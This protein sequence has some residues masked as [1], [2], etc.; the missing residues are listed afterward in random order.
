MTSSGPV[1]DAWCYFE[2]LKALAGGGDVAQVVKVFEEMNERGVTP[3]V[4]CY[5]MVIT[6]L[7]KAGRFRE[8]RGLLQDMREGVVRGVDVSKP[9]A[10]M[11]KLGNI[12]VGGTA[13]RGVVGSSLTTDALHSERIDCDD[14]ETAG[15]LE[16][17]G[18][19]EKEG[20][21]TLEHQPGFQVV[22]RTAL[23][24]EVECWEGGVVVGEI[25]NDGAR[26]QA[27]TAG[28]NEVDVGVGVIENALQGRAAGR[29]NVVN[30]GGEVRKNV[31]WEG[32]P[33]A[34]GEFWR[35]VSGLGLPLPTEGSLVDRGADWIRYWGNTQ[36]KQTPR[37]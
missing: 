24:D 36:Q 29:L 3:S 6:A 12:E 8:A 16:Q 27:G 21:G 35:K 11:E 20:A 18:I 37:V 9:D 26:Q 34:H 33:S 10:G 17:T 32:S 15:S 4:R 7:C 30:G 5:N 25:M 19:P 22:D 13:V 31:E 2:V 1:P 28:A 14:G 23:H